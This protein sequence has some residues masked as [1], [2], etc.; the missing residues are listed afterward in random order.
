MHTQLQAVLN[1]A[2][3]AVSGKTQV[4]EKMLLA[5]LAGGHILL[6]DVPGLG[7]TT[8]AIAISRALGA[9]FRRIQCTPD[10]IASDI[11]GFS[12]YNKQTGAFT[13]MPGVV[14][15]CNILLADELNRTASKTQSALLEAMQEGQVT[16][17][18]QT[19]PLCKPFT[20]IA[21]QNQVGTAGTQLLPYAQLDRFMLRLQIGYPDF[22]GQ[23]EI[24]RSRQA[25]N[26]LDSVEPALSVREILQMQQQVCCVSVHEVILAYITRLAMASRENP[27]IALGISP[28]GALHISA[29]A[30]ARAFLY[31]RD[32]VIDEDVCA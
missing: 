20:V 9:K 4:L 28:R 29:A 31:G 15:D 22:D 5:I 10:V 3:K 19:H 14:T 7:K 1:Q 12:M 32:Y 24:L 18:G 17:D 11:V 2:S 30:R 23:M 8:M 27:M 6:D 21:T 16:V 13:Y 25:E 26:P